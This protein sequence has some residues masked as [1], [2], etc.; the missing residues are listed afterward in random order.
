M[1]E[2]LAGFGNEW[3]LR[4][5]ASRVRSA[6]GVAFDYWWCTAK[7]SKVYCRFVVPYEGSQHAWLVF[8]AT[9]QQEKHAVHENG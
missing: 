2:S 3:S 9:E 5:A 6:V 4:S 1:I 8:I 7:H